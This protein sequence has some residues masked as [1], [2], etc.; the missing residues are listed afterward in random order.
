MYTDILVEVDVIHLLTIVLFNDFRIRYSSICFSKKPEK[1]FG[2]GQAD[3]S[4]G[5]EAFG[6]RIIVEE[7]F[8]IGVMHID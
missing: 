1:I 4:M 2:L 6:W 5:L 3:T 8:I 7:F